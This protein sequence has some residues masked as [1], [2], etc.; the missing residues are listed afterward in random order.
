M[1]I[2]NERDVR[3]FSHTMM[4]RHDQWC[5]HDEDSGLVKSERREFTEQDNDDDDDDDDDEAFFFCFF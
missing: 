1:N 4:R 2:E 3:D 5:E